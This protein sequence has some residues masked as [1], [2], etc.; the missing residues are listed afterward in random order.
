[1]A[2]REAATQK[3]LGVTLKLSQQPQGLIDGLMICD[4]TKT[5]QK[6]GLE[7]NGLNFFTLGDIENGLSTRYK[8][9]S[10]MYQVWLGAYL[11]EHKKE[12]WTPDD[13]LE[14]AVAD[15]QKWLS[16]YGLK[17]PK[18]VFDTHQESGSIKS[19]NYAGKLYYWYGNTF[20]DVG[21]H[22]SSLY[23][24]AIMEGMAAIMSKQNP[25]LELIGSN[26]L[27]ANNRT[28]TSYEPT[29]LEGYCGLFK[30]RPGLTVVMYVASVTNNLKK[31]TLTD[32]FKAL[33]IVDLK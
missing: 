27:P 31:S 26:F 24:K 13:Y 20:S 23:S 19:G 17:N 10:L 29:P 1:M 16:Y 9:E 21:Y 6:H 2:N 4:M 22:S 3:R 15:Q 5:W 33:Q 12:V 30:I 32:Y 25:Q 7:C 14:L 18:M 11:V 28:L 8:K